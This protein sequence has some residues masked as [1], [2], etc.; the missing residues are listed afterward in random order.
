MRRNLTNHK[1]V[2]GLYLRKR[3]VPTNNEDPECVKTWRV[4]T[5]QTCRDDIESKGNHIALGELL[6]P[7]GYL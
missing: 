6:S 2:L 7:S 5:T 4:G 3:G 1:R